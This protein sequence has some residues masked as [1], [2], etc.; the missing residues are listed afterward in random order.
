MLLSSI[1]FKKRNK[2]IEI[3]L[4]GKNNTTQFQNKYIKNNYKIVQ[5]Y[6]RIKMSTAYGTV[7]WAKLQGFQEWPSRVF[8]NN[9]FNIINDQFI[10]KTIKFKQ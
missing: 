6:N 2:F 10:I 4:A 8:N 9:P 7:I 3:I 1:L 5:K